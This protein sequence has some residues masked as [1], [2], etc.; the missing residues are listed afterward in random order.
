[1]KH[2]SD[3]DLSPLRRQARDAVLRARELP[4][5]RDRNE[6]RHLALGLRGLAAIQEMQDWQSPLVGGF[7]RSRSYQVESRRP[8]GSIKLNHRF[9]RLLAW[10][11]VARE[12]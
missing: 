9:A 5:G 6:L 8:F 10:S 11:M 2:A 4:V 7:T 12:R 3:T 1:M